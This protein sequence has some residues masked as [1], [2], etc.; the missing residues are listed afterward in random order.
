L[1]ICVLPK[2]PKQKKFPAVFQYHFFYVANLLSQNRCQDNSILI[3]QMI[4]V[5]DIFLCWN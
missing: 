4:W 1:N 2:S 3:H 5:Q